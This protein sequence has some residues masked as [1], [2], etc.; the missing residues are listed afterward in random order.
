MQS[1]QAIY[2]PLQRQ[3][4]HEKNQCRRS[5]GSSEREIM[6][7]QEKRILVMQT[8]GWIGDMILLTPAL[9]SLKQEYPD[10]HIEILVNPLV[11]ELMKRN[12]Y[13][14][15]VIV[16]DK[17]KSQKG[18]RKLSQLSRDLRDC[19]FDTA[20]IM[21][22]SSI[23]SAFIAFKAGI[24]K[25]IGSEGK[26]R[27]LFL[28]KKVK[29][30][31]N[32]HEV[33]RYMEL[34][35]PITEPNYDDRL[36]FWG[37]RDED[38]EFA[39]NAFNGKTRPLIGI[40]PST[41]WPT[42]HWMPERF[43]DLAKR[44]HNDLGVTVFFTGGKNDDHL[45]EKLLSANNSAL[46]FIGKTNLWQLGALIQECD[47]FIT[48]DSGPVHISA[49]L[50]ISTVSL[51]GPTDPCR[52][53]PYGEIHEAIR[54]NDQCG[55]CYSRECRKSVCMSMIQVDDVFKVV[56]DKLGEKFH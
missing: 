27:G 18:Y 7:G 24:P 42:K 22:P 33:R 16:Y 13:L 41:T 15:G 11:N 29:H 44:L 19:E 47:L 37:I 53:R 50:G 52:H 43:A 48:C 49:A 56:R 9:R 36:E 14:D 8:G 26:G 23:R 39:T 4:L 5:V 28:T 35:E 38:K 31:K 6:S 55:P 20:I 3:H 51:F 32:I 54:K 12:P 2:R 45:R 34:I 25:R 46:D 10:S 40:N 21:H 30:D 17:R 1:M